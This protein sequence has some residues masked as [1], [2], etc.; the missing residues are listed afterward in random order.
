MIIATKKGKIFLKSDGLPVDFT[1]LFKISGIHDI[2]RLFQAIEPELT[3]FDLDFRVD[4][5]PDEYMKRIGK[6]YRK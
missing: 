2:L 6:D 1:D 4:N 5:T 3:I